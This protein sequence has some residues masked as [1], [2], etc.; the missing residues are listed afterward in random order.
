MRV[1]LLGITVMT[2]ET[3][4]IKPDYKWN[5]LKDL[6]FQKLNDDGSLLLSLL[7]LKCIRFNFIKSLLF[8]SAYIIFENMP[9]LRLIS[10]LETLLLGLFKSGYS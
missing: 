4:L 7:S 9:C 5:C 10:V 8:A 1:G 3:R 6:I 2:C